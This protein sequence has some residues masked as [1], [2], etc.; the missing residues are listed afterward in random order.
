MKQKSLEIPDYFENADLKHFSNVLSNL[1]WGNLGAEWAQQQNPRGFGSSRQSTPSLP[2]DKLTNSLI[3]ASYL[4]FC[5]HFIVCKSI[6]CELKGEKNPKIKGEI[7]HFPTAWLWPGVWEG[8]FPQGPHV[9]LLVWILRIHLGIDYKAPP[10]CPLRISKQL[11]CPACCLQP[12]LRS[13][14]RCPGDVPLPGEG[15]ASNIPRFPN[16][17]SNLAWSFRHFCTKSVN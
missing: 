11:S 16:N 2:S 7:Q 6:H 10:S 1:K 4:H 14:T 5:S 13:L 8:L 17:S 15:N 3:K 9:P 12:P